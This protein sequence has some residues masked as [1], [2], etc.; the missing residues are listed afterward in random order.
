MWSGPRK[1]TIGWRRRVTPL[2]VDAAD[3]GLLDLSAW[4]VYDGA[5]IPNCVTFNQ[6]EWTYNNG[7]LLSGAAFLYNYVPTPHPSRPS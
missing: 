3:L 4:A 7:Q 6:I 2:C 5:S 1:Y